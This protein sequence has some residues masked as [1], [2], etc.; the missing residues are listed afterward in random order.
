MAM[1]LRYREAQG[2]S[3]DP[4]IERAKG[5]AIVLVVLGHVVA[6]ELP[7]GNEWFAAVK[8]AIYGFHMPFFLFLSG[9]TFSRSGF[10]AQSRVDFPLYLSSRSRRFLPPYLIFA[11]IV[12]CAKFVGQKFLHVDQSVSGFESFFGIFLFP[13]V[14][15][16]SFLWYIWVLY[17]LQVLFPILLRII[18]S[19]LFWCI[20]A[21]PLTLISLPYWFGIDKLGAFGFFFF[22]GYVFSENK[23]AYIDV[24]ERYWKVFLVCFIILLFVIDA[25]RDRLMTL[26]LGS[27]SIPAIHGLCR[28]GVLSQSSILAVVGG[29]S[30][31][32]Y[33]MNTMAIGAAKGVLLIFLDW[34][35]PNFFF[36]LPI[37][38]IAGIAAPVFVKV[39]ILNR[40]GWLR[41]IS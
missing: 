18:N 24:L 12:F 7:P 30:F 8:W 40:V 15:V 32:I 6:R 20:L 5:V 33:L 13:T 23:G 25:P 16:V 31:S 3:R 2:T 34:G 36:V 27:F 11:L 29:F 22:L 4:D 21:C 35:G 9:Y 39:V 1:T 14:S 38:L 28:F 26:I 17:L 10:V 19:P 41:R 37:L